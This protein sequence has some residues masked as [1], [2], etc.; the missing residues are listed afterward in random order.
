[1]VRDDYTVLNQGQLKAVAD[2]FYK[3]LNEVG[4]KGVPLRR[5]QTRPWSAATDDDD[6]FAAANLG[7]LKFMFSF[8]PLA[9]VLVDS[10]QDGIDDR[11][12]VLNFDQ[13]TTV[14][15][16]SHVVIGARVGDYDGDGFSDLEEFLLGTDPKVAN[17][18]VA[19]GD[20]IVFEYDNRARLRG[21]T[22]QGVKA[23]YTP[24]AENN[25]K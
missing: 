6:A 25:L 24:D 3:R 22:G 2:L 20:A 8:V 16:P 19:P 14:Q 18:Q 1:V 15:N 4:Y 7:Q 21:A 13:L 11:W 9:G 12:E 23:T 5:G 17:T 10:D